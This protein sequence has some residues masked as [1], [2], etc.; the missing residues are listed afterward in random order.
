MQLL[1]QI[2]INF[3]YQFVPVCLVFVL[4]LGR[5]IFYSVRVVSVFAFAF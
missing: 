5:G 4:R 1:L 3:I 2:E